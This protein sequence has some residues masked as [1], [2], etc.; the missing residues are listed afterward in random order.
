MHVNI[1]KTS[2]IL[3]IYED[4]QLQCLTKVFTGITIK[5]TKAVD[6]SYTTAQNPRLMKTVIWFIW[7][8]IFK[9]QLFEYD[10]S[11]KLVTLPGKISN[12][13]E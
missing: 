6:L 2:I 8:W 4:Y 3:K 1:I 12:L 11:Y 5:P 9:N 7:S 13:P 10:R